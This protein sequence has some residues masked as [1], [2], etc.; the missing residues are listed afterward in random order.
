MGRDLQSYSLNTY[1]NYKSL[2]R[3]VVVRGR[4]HSAACMALACFRG[5]NDSRK[6]FDD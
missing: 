4:V 6:V 5:R 1:Y 3:R 2:T